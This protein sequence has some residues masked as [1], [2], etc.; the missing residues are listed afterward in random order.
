MLAA[1]NWSRGVEYTICTLGNI[2]VLIWTGSPTVD[3]VNA[4]SLAFGALRRGS[5]TPQVGFLTIIEPIAG[6]GTMPTS[7]RNALAQMLKDNENFLR[8]AAI[9]FEGTGFRATVVRSVVTAI[10]MAARPKFHSSVF[11]D[12]N[13]GATWLMHQ[14]AESSSVKLAELLS[15]IKNTREIGVSVTQ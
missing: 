1:Q 3:G 6:Q 8:A 11:S 10:Q 7:V 5:S 4:C 14:M 12:R 2:V 13:A 15:L 9:V